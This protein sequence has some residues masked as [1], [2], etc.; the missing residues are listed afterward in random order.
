ML[1][2]GKVA[3][4]PELYDAA[5]AAPEE[6][7]TALASATRR[8][9][10]QSWSNVGIEAPP[11]GGSLATATPARANRRG[12][13][14]S[15][16]AVVVAIAVAQVIWLGLLG[17]RVRAPRCAWAMTLGKRLRPVLTVVSIVA[18]GA[19]LLTFWFRGAS[20]LMLE[21]R[22]RSTV[23]HLRVEHRDSAAL[24]GRP[25]ENVAPAAIPRV[26]R[27]TQRG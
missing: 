7:S 25:D 3:A 18:V 24:R 23:Q 6:V 1:E 19:L 21:L 14:S 15:R 17:S 9:V 22:R 11:A 5:Q 13:A 8:Q 4:E 10:Q 20:V 12:G 16:L 2:G 26:R 27:R